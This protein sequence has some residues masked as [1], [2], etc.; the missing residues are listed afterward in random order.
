MKLW[1]RQLALGLLLTAAIPPAAVRA[2]DSAEQILL[3]KANYWRLKD[4]PDLARDA[5][6]KLLS[7]NPMQADALYAYGVL[8][9]QQGDVAVAR[10]YLGRLRQAAPTDPRVAALDSAIGGGRVDQ[11]P[12][13]SAS[14]TAKRLR[15]PPVACREAER[16]RG[17]GRGR[18]RYRQAVAADPKIL[19]GPAS[20]MPGSSPGRARR[21]RG[22]RR[23]TR[24]LRA[25]RPPRFTL[26]PSSTTSSTG[27]PM[28]W[29]SSIASRR[30]SAPPT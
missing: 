19:L 15:R 24:R 27:R 2:A 6:D 8:E 11:P 10:G 1:A 9:L 5:L 16:H 28:R 26:R 21:R 20:T 25:I 7:V 23:W 29:P 3:D 12:K 13:A 14:Q 17:R 18:A 4:R 22:S 30:R